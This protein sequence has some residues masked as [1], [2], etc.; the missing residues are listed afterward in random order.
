VIEMEYC[1]RNP[2]A[3]L[4]F[5]NGEV[6]NLVEVMDFDP[7]LATQWTECMNGWMSAMGST[8]CE[9]MF[10]ADGKPFGISMLEEVKDE[11]AMLEALRSLSSDL[12]T[13]GFSRLYESMGMPM[14][15][16]FEE[17]VRTADGI[18]I[19]RLGMDFEL[20]N[21]P[22]EQAE[23]LESMLG[24]MS[25]DLAIYKDVLIYTTGEGAVE[26]IIEQMKSGGVPASTL[27]AR[28]AF[29]SGGFYY[30]DFDVGGYLGCI[31]SSMDEVPDASA[32]VDKFTA[33][34]QGAEPVV[35]TG[36][37]NNGRLKFCSKIPADLLV[38]AAQAGQMMA[39]ETMQ[40]KTAMQTTPAPQSPAGPAPDGTLQLLDGSAVPLSGFTGQKVVVLDFWASWCGP[41]RKGLPMVQA[42]SDYFTGRDVVFYAVNLREDIDKV[43]PFFDGAGLSLPVALDDGTLSEAFGVTGI[44]HTVVIGKDGNIKSVHTGFSPDLDVLLTAE[45]NTA[46]AE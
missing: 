23:I 46:L 9:S 37:C 8:V 19:H 18:N 11:S 7:A 10:T 15:V 39:L 27:A 24:D 25:F 29:P 32:M 5:L 17:N 35:M 33:V 34:M 1:M 22:P 20:K 3:L 38:R 26:K 2:D 14:T 43:K 28:A 6:A 44:P 12:D 42:V 13:L 4:A 16:K 30:A 31:S 40:K 36:Y 21:I 41:C 45:I